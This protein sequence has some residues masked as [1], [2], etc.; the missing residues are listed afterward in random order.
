MSCVCV[1]IKGSSWAF[2]GRMDPE[3]LFR[4]IFGDR[5]FKTSGFDDYD[6]FVESDFGFATA[7]H[8]RAKVLK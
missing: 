6:D 4:Q 1:L 7:S 3:E 2:H 5:G 8:V